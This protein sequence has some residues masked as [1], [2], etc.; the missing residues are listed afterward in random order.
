MKPKYADEVVEVSL[1][2]AQGLV[3]LGVLVGYDWASEYRGT[4]D[5]DDS[6]FFL[7]PRLAGRTRDHEELLLISSWRG[8]F[9][10]VPKGEING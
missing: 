9:F 7:D 2:E 8:A 6:G 4:S 5:T 3:D 1:E 10:F